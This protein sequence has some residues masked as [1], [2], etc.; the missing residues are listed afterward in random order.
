VKFWDT[1]VPPAQKIDTQ[2]LSRLFKQRMNPAKTPR[3]GWYCSGC[4][5]HEKG[6]TKSLKEFSGCFLVLL[7]YHL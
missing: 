4:V 1:A 5:V 2:A 6:F 3:F 7:N